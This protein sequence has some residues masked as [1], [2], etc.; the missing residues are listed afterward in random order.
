[1]RANV[2]DEFQSFAFVTVSTQKNIR[3]IETYFFS[4]F[5]P[6]KPPPREIPKREGPDSERVKA[7]DD[8][9]TQ[10]PARSK[11][12]ENNN[13]IIFKCLSRWQKKKWWN[14]MLLKKCDG[15]SQC[16]IQSTWRCVRR[17]S[18]SKKS[19]TKYEIVS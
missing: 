19:N 13:R 5:P 11:T 17:P 18:R 2:K 10:I 3:I 6:N 16:S 7:G 14:K 9:E 8:E 12:V 1:M 15:I 4:S